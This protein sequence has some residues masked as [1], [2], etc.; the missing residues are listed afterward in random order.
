SLV[1]HMTNFGILWTDLT[2]VDRN[3]RIIILC[4]LRGLDHLYLIVY[5]CIDQIQMI[6]SES[7]NLSI[8]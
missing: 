4:H 6:E 5:G 2:S 3:L 8:H 1:S 7:L